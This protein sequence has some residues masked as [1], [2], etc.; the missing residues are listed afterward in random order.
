MKNIQPVFLKD[1]DSQ[2][3]RIVFLL[4]QKEFYLKQSDIQENKLL[5]QIFFNEAQ[6]CE[7]EILEIMDK[8]SSD[9]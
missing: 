5:A 3:S 2:L 8:N 7:E 6:I 9:I 4:L 1:D